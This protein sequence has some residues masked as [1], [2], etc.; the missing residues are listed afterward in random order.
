M[1]VKETYN[2]TNLII[3]IPGVKVSGRPTMVA[4]L[5]AIDRIS[6]EAIIFA[7]CVIANYYTGSHDIWK[8]P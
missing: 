3:S 8:S 2:V 7:V 5:I 4:F 1:I 6:L